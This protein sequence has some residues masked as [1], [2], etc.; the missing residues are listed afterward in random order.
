MAVAV[1][2]TLLNNARCYTCLPPGIVPYL[3]LAQLL[4]GGTVAS[5]QTLL[6]Q[7]ACL[8]CQIP[9]GLVGYVTIAQLA[10]G[11]VGNL[12]GSVDPNGSVTGA[13]GQIYTQVVGSSTTIWVNTNGGTA[14]S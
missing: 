5:P 13:L 3:I 10:S 12:T 6:D 2:Q 4:N 11:G 1:S 9:P 7:A 8:V 14:W